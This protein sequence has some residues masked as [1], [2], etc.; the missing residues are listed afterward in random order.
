M[1]QTSGFLCK[2]FILVSEGDRTQKSGFAIGV[3]GKLGAGDFG[4]S[5]DF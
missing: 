1:F 3:A 5:P 4:E 2:C